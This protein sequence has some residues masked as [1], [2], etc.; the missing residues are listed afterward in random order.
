LIVKLS[1]CEYIWRQNVVVARIL[2]ISDEEIE[3]L[4][5]GNLEARCFSQARRAAFRFAKEALERIE[6]TDAT[7]AEAAV[8][9]S[10]RALLEI[11][12]V[13]GSYMFLARVIRTGRI[14]LDETPAEV[15]DKVF[16]W[17]S[18]RP[19][20]RRADEVAARSEYE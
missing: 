10:S 5:K 13:I 20:L 16:D 7:Y 14:P 17:F 3:E 18:N 8:H 4:H 6:V 2:G 15:P 1:G 11:L 12:Y 9:F 19:A